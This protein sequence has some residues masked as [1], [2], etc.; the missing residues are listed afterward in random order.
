M[1]RKDRVGKPVTLRI[2]V[3]TVSATRHDQTFYTC[4]ASDPSIMVIAFVTP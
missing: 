2:N 1:D 3:F 4:L